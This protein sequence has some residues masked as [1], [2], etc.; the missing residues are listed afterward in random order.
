M[1]SDLM[2]EL[3][4]DAKL[5][6]FHTGADALEYF[7]SGAHIDVCFLDILMPEMTGITLA[8]RLRENGFDGRIVFQTTTNDF[9]SEA[10]G[11]EAFFY[12]LK[13]PTME[14]VEKILRKLEAAQKETD[15]GVIMIKTASS[16]VPVV[17]RDI[18]H[19]EV[20]NHTVYLRLMSGD[21]LEV[22]IVFNENAVEAC[23][24]LKTARR[25]ELYV[26][27]TDGNQ[28]VA[29]G[30]NSCADDGA[31]WIE[32]G[33]L[34]SAKQD[35]GYGLRSIQTVAKRHGGNMQTERDKDKFMTYV[36]LNL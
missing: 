33:Q 6:F 34:V 23:M 3:K 13:P 5:K 4:S 29:Y 7:H 27:V 28:L 21:E 25:I 36:R 22:N 2:L 11:V 17:F 10:F 8:E 18:S 9:A 12:M 19:A 32:D 24:K 14:S 26:K 20:I 16:L 1:L 15:I 30:Q 35:G 31:L